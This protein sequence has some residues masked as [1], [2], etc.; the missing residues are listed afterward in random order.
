VDNTVDTGKSGTYYVTYTYSAN[1]S[2]GTAILTVV[3]E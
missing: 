3:V 1:G 2:T